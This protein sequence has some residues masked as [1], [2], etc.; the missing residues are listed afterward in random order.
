M[1]QYDLA[2]EM[3][4]HDAVK[5]SPQNP[6]TWASGV[7]S[8]I[9]CDQRVLLSY[10]KTRS[11]IIAAYVDLIKTN[12]P[13]VQ[14]IVGTA[15]SGIPYGAIIADHLNLPFAY[16]RA[17]KKDHGKRQNIEGKL[18]KNAKVIVIEDLISTG[19]SV[20]EVVDILLENDFSVLGVLANFTYQLEIADRNFARYQISYN[21]LSNIAVL[22]EIATEQKQITLDEHNIIQNF[23]Q[24][25][26]KES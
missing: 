6:F 2:Q 3:L 5:L 22:L 11:K 17:S 26:F 15:T 16:V 25:N 7:K 10:P 19:K 24:T 21:A 1:I 8:P 13:D 18:E 23:L 14:A 20:L 9:Y 12:Y 4:E